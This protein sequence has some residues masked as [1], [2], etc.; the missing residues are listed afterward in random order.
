MSSR[1]IENAIREYVGEAPAHILACASAC[2]YD[3]YHGP[4]FS[5]LPAQGV[6][7]FTVDDYATFA[8][9]L[10]LILGE[11]DTI[12]ETYCGPIGDALRAYIETLPSE[13]YVDWSGYATDCE[14]QGEYLDAEGEPCDGD[15]E[16]A[17]W[18]EPEGYTLCDQRD[19]IA[20]IFGDFMAKEFS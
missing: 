18:C 9:D 6:E 10:E 7:A 13:L 2:R 19:I 11:G 15:A 14:P 1:E 20:A 12:T 16:G 17:E 8:S 5:R 3:L 4:T